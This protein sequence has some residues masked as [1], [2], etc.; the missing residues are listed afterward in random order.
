MKL[1]LLLSCTYP[2]L[3]GKATGFLFRSHVLEVAQ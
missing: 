2:V 1:P 3:W